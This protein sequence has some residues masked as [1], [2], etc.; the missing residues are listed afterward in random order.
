MYLSCKA[1]LSMNSLSELVRIRKKDDAW[2][3][4]KWRTKFLVEGRTLLACTR[5]ATRCATRDFLHNRAR[6]KRGGDGGK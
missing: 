5:E 2:A 6:K 1:Y 3:N 4:A